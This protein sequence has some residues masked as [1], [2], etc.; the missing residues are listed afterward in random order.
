MY[1]LYFDGACKLNPG[2]TGCG[3]VVFNEAGEVA[4]ELSKANG[5]GTNN[6]A[7]YSALIFGLEKAKEL[8]I[9]QVIVYGDSKLVINQLNGIWNCNDPA[10]RLLNKRAMKLCYEFAFIEL[11][12]IKRAENS[13]ADKLSQ[14]AL[15][16]NTHI[17][18]RYVAYEPPTAVSSSKVV[19]INK[20]S[21]NSVTA[22]HYYKKIG[23]SVIH[24]GKLFAINLN[25][26]ECSCGVKS[27]E[28]IR[29]AIEY[30]QQ[31]NQK[32]LGCS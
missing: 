25:P 11:K 3:A 18:K 32:K 17:D 22:I 13:H 2:P 23:F 14:M 28:H 12:W 9:Q 8:G 31:N 30:S 1:K 26:L 27:C 5:H 4:A 20:Q 19:N 10:L 6:Q 16:D 21:D 15:E 29:A 24:A 7:E